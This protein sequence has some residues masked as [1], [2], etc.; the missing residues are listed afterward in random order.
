MPHVQHL[1]K[2]DLLEL[3]FSTI[4]TRRFLQAQ[5]KLGQQDTAIENVERVSTLAEAAAAAVDTTSTAR[6]A[7]I[8]SRY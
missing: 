1:D 7:A 5:L 2:E 4:E 6:V 3:D 8:A